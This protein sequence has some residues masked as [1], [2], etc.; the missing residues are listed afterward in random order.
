M[1]ANG[2]RRRT[3]GTG[4]IIEKNGHYYAQWRANGRLIKRKLGPVRVAGT[5]DGMTKT[6]AEAKLR[7]LI[8]E[9]VPPRRWSSA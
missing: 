1:S 4:S 5:R 2:N 6:M 9:L 3:C 7:S 8:S